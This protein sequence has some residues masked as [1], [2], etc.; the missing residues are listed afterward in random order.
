MCKDAVVKQQ[1]K[2]D[3]Q[4][5]QVIRAREFGGAFGEKLYEGDFG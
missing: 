4:S 1:D 3:R 2:G 5:T